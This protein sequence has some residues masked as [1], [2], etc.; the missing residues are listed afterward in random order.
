MNNTSIRRSLDGTRRHLFFRWASNRYVMLHA[1]TW[2]VMTLDISETTR[3]CRCFAIW[4]PH[5]GKPGLFLRQLCHSGSLV[6]SHKIS[7]MRTYALTITPSLAR[8]CNNE[9]YDK[10]RRGARSHLRD[11]SHST[12]PA[13]TTASAF[14]EECRPQSRVFSSVNRTGHCRLALGVRVW[15]APLST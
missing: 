3:N 10:P 1:F 11:P 9:Q 5:Q 14:S 4:L 6:L 13:T 2:V 12:Q 15:R 7:T 8:S